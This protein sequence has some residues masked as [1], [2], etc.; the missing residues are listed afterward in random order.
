MRINWVWEIDWSSWVIGF[1]VDTDRH[2][3][4]NLRS[5]FITFY[6][7]PILLGLDF[8]GKEHN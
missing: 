7:G 6:F 5:Y 1:E 8:D 2:W 3:S 4:R